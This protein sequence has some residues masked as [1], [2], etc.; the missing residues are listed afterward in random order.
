[1]VEPAA[2]GSR[3]TRAAALSVALALP[4][5]GLALLLL[6]PHCDRHWEHHPAHFW[7]VLEHGRAQRRSRLRHR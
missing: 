4:L 6:R 5:V 3:P 7:L 2:A 1:M